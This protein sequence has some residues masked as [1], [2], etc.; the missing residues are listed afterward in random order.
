[1][2][3]VWIGR[4]VV[5]RRWMIAESGADVSALERGTEFSSG[6]VGRWILTQTMLVWVAGGLGRAA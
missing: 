3:N 6:P 5:E 4:R 1:M 2:I